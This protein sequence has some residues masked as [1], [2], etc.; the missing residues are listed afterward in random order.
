[1]GRDSGG[2]VSKDRSDR[3]AADFFY[4]HVRDENLWQELIAHIDNA[5]ER[6]M[7]LL[8]AP[9]SVLQ[10]TSSMN[11]WL[12]FGTRLGKRDS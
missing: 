8:S 10:L 5:I 4:H 11:A 1:M 9:V 2:A 6:L 3:G 12:E 7:C